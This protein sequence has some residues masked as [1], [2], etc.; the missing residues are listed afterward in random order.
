MS[1]YVDRIVSTVHEAEEARSE[2]V[3]DQQQRWQYRFHR[4]R[5]WFDK[6]VHHAQT[7]LKQ[8]IPSFLWHGSVPNLLTTPIIYSII[9][10]FVLLDIWV[11]LYQWICFP[12]YGIDRVPRWYFAIDRHKLG[13]LNAIEKANCMYCS[14]ANGVVAYVREIAGRTEEYWCPIK[15]ARAVPSPHTHYQLF[16]DYETRRAI[17]AGCPASGRCLAANDSGAFERVVARDD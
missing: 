17:A 11:S 14:Y 15:H 1:R 2:D 3:C 10:P 13:Y 12:I 7:Q 16:F 9:L 4:G 6:E 8:G 5:I